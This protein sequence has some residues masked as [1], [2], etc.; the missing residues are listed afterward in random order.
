MASSP[1]PDRPLFA[2][3]DELDLDNVASAVP[4]ANVRGAAI[5]EPG[6]RGYVA[7]CGAVDLDPPA[8]SHVSTRGAATPEERFAEIERWKEAELARVQREYEETK[9]RA[10]EVR[11][12]HHVKTFGARRAH[13]GPTRARRPSCNTRH[14]GSRRGAS[15]RSSSRG[16]DSGD[17]DPESDSH[18][19]SP[20]FLGGAGR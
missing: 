11:R 16:G 1:E 12:R 7:T 2:A 13:R 5:P 6:G 18:Q 17:P 9:A 19:L 15:T 4:M 14:K 8:T 3:L 10:D 20:L